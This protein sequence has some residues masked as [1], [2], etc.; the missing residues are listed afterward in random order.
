MAAYKRRLVG[1]SGIVLLVLLGA[2][3]ARGQ[4]M[5][6]SPQTYYLQRADLPPGAIG[7]AQLFRSPDFRGYYQPVELLVPDTA[8]LAVAE[9]GGFSRPEAGNLKV[10]LRIGQVYRF[11]ISGIRANQGRE[12]YPSVEV[13]NRLHPPR[14]QELRFPIPIEITN[15]E[16]QLALNGA[17]ITRVIYLETPDL[18][19]ALPEIPGSP[20]VI[21]VGGQQDPLRVADRMGRPMA[22]L[23]IGSRIPDVDANG[24][25][26]YHTPSLLRYGKEPPAPKKI[27]TLGK[28]PAR[29]GLE[30]TQG[31]NV[32]PRLP[33]TIGARFQWAQPQRI[34][35]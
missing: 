33:D 11:Q 12:V 1:S 10:G 25:F 21:Q 30:E 31:G 24:R 20:Q 8:R 7:Q 35:R 6:T 26:T 29:I 18:A 22:I 5:V 13:I 34:I 14:G 28:D 15:E 9:P 27:D 16:L 2:S 3:L 23:R 19:T 17:F 4:Q 32:Y